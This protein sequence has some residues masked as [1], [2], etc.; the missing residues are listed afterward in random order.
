M[1]T[2]YET[3][4]FKYARSFTDC[5]KSNDITAGYNRDNNV[6]HWCTFSIYHR[7][8]MPHLELI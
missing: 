2:F 4:P 3:F 6:L 7:E 5:S 1:Q 8:N